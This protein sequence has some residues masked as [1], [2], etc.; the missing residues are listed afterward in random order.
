M[1]RD[2]RS[3]EFS[4]SEWTLLHIRDSVNIS[5]VGPKGIRGQGKHFWPV[6]NAQPG[7]RGYCLLKFE[8]C[9]HIHVSGLKLADAPMYQLVVMYSEDVHLEDLEITVQRGS[10]RPHNTDG[11]SI[12]ASTRVHL[13]N[14]MIESGD[15]NVVVKEGSH[16]VHAEGLRLFGGKGV[17][18]GSLG[19][20]GAKDQVVTDVIFR[21]VSL[22]K[23]VHGARIKTW[24]GSRGLIRNVSF[25][26]FVVEDVDIGI[27]IDQKYCPS[28]QRPEGC[29]E[30]DVDGIDIE[31]VHFRSFTGT[32]L[33]RDRDISCV[34]CRD[35]TYDGIVMRYSQTSA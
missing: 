29:P 25:E 8:R 5:I 3:P 26:S 31:D 34:H 22:R 16:F 17:S 4:R 33:R 6:R 14:S 35:I 23:S 2:G 21:N 30:S 28:S 9:A 7:V 20:R 19:E 32:V 12:I 24:K 15:D 1:R 27:L 13:R 11:V 18:I 10:L